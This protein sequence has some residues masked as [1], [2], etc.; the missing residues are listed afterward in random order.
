M[1]E[2]KSPTKGNLKA[3]VLI[4][5][6]EEKGENQQRLSSPCPSPPNDLGFGGK[7]AQEGGGK[8]A[9]KKG[10]SR[11][12]ETGDQPITSRIKA[13]KKTKKG[14]MEKAARRY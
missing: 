1:N 12:T 6:C 8:R 4:N 14:L 5:R 7:L 3:I 10:E 11:L 2:A 13:E 9:E